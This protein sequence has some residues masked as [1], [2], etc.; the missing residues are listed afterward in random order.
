MAGGGPIRPP[1]WPQCALN[2]LDLV[3]ET[4]RHAL[5]AL[6]I[7]APAWL[8]AQAP[9]EWYDRYG[10]RLET[11]RR[12]LTAAQRDALAASIGADGLS[13]SAVGDPAAPPWRRERPAVQTLRQ[14]WLQNYHAPADPRAGP[15]PHEARDQPPKARAIESPYDPD[16]RF[17]TKRETS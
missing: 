17:H 7:A 14:V 1:C 8:R 12:A 3:G 15:R 11:G 6:A 10:A 13:C 9:P 5:E 16:A 2:R 4:L